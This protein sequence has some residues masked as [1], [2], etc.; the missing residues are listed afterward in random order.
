MSKPPKQTGTS[1]AGPEPSL[2]SKPDPNTSKQLGSAF[3][4]SKSGLYKLKNS[5]YAPTSHTFSMRML[6]PGQADGSPQNQKLFDFGSL[7]LIAVRRCAQ[8]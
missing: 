2:A 1:S 7:P 6:A 3:I 8:G 5:A 4:E